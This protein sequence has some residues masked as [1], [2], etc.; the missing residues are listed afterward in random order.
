MELTTGRVQW[1][2]LVLVLNVGFF[3]HSVI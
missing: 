2:A 3:Y 1:R